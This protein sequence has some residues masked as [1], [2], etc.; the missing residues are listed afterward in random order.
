MVFVEAQ[1]AGC[2]VI[3]TGMG[4]ALEA[5]EKNDNNIFLDGPDVSLLVDALTNRLAQ[6]GG[7]SA[8]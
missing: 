5:I 3:T 1:L 6:M 4:G 7:A 8:S 2:S